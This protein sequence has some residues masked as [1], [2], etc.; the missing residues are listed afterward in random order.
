MKLL[1]KR[2]PDGLLGHAL[3]LMAGVARW[4]WGLPGR[5]R[6]G[7]PE[8]TGVRRH[9]LIAGTARTIAGDRTKSR[10]TRGWAMT[11]TRRPGTLAA[12]MN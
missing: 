2:S 4:S 1:L 3:Q 12:L 10:I 6:P 9:F 7:T 8:L 11:Q 5:Q